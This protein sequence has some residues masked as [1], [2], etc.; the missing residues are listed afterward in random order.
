MNQ[1]VGKQGGKPTRVKLNAN[2]KNTHTFEK[3]APGP[4]TLHRIYIEASTSLSFL[5]EAVGALRDINLKPA[6]NRYVSTGRA[7]RTC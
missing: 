5:R 7:R 3:R 4:H 2:K 1:N 6:V